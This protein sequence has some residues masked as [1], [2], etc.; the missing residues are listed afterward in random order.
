MPILHWLDRD[1]HTK[2]SETLP[3]RLLEARDEHSA[4]DLETPNMLIQGDNLEALKALLP[5]YAGRVK[6]IFIDPP[7]NTKTA[8]EHYDDNLE[9]SQWLSM[10]V[11][12]LQLLRDLLATEGSIW[13]TIDDNEAHYLKVLMDE[14]FGRNSFVANIVWQKR[15]SRENRKA[16]GSAHDHILVYSPLGPQRWKDFRNLLPDSDKGYSN[17]DK[18]DKGRWRSIPFSAQGFRTNQMYKIETP[19][20]KF[21]F[22]PRKK[23][24]KSP[25]K[26]C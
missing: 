6:C 3:Y 5:F 20:G 2:A 10:M 23:A 15:T 7:Y 22:K 25:R 4:G 26:F 21:C 11:P 19:T 13:I 9:H 8:F 24:K 16:V 17:P 18:D 12:R 14:V 1:K